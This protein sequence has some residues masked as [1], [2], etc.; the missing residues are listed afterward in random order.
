MTIALA[1]ADAA[2]LA[3]DPDDDMTLLLAALHALDV[4]AQAVDW[5]ATVD[6]G[7][8]DL[9]VLRSPWNYSAHFAQFNRWLDQVNVVSRLLN[10][11]D[12]LRW[13]M[14]KHYLVDLHSHGVPVVPT[15]FVSTA[16]ELHA[17][18]G[19]L[20]NQ[21]V[22]LKPTISA[23][24]KDTGLFDNDDPAMLQ[25]AQRIIDSGRTV[26]VQPEI[27]SVSTSGEKALIFFDGEFSHAVHK[28]PI[29]APGGGLIG[30]VY[31]EVISAVTATTDELEVGRAAIGVAQNRKGGTH[32]PP[33]Y[34]RIDL[35]DADGQPTVLEAEMVEPSCFLRFAADAPA[36]FAQAISHRWG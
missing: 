31:Q 19:R 29:L 34:A 8:Y 16:P 17:A 10:D 27:A 33:L 7:T 13:N 3:A 15:E 21:R 23:G 14:D 24:S 4:D 36:R 25:L 26:M 9:V 30:G 2:T 12:L 22:V 35:A 18:L 28:G 32:E 1:T 6:W 11:L 20:P 5:R